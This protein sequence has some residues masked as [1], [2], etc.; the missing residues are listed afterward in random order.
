MSNEIGA[1]E[2]KATQRER[3]E[4]ILTGQLERTMSPAA[5][6]MYT[7]TEFAKLLTSTAA[8]GCADIKGPAVKATC[9]ALG[10]KNTY[11]AIKEFLSKE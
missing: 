1:V 5:S 8:I 7:P 9:K 4:I 11:K 10:I 6:E 3:F 2:Y